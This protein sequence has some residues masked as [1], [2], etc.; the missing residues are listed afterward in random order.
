MCGIM[1][2]ITLPDDVEIKQLITHVDDRGF[3]REIIRRNDDFFREGFSQWSHSVKKQDYYTA[4]FHVHQ[5]QVDWWYVPIGE[6]WVVLF[7]LR[8]D[9]DASLPVEIIMDD[10]TGVLRIPPG[11]AHGF[12]VLKGPAHLMYVTSQT[13]NPS[14]E[15][16]VT[17]NYEW[18]R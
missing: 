8:P 11:V 5:F 18:T 2:L 1:D 4:Q 13:Y 6:L 12:K 17:L 16:R 14:D 7:D 15:G 3:F 9:G 10:S